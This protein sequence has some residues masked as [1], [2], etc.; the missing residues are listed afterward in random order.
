MP[1]GDVKL[2]IRAPFYAKTKIEIGGAVKM[3]IR[4]S[5]LCLGVLRQNR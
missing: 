3:A 5:L 1:V 2:A 4:G